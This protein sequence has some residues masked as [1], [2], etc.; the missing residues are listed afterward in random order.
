MH[1]LTSTSVCDVHYGLS[2][3]LGAWIFTTLEVASDL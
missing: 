1:S 2:K 3:L